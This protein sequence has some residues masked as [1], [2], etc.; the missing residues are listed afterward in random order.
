MQRTCERMCTQT[1]GSEHVNKS[2]QNRERKEHDIYLLYFMLAKQPL[3]GYAIVK[4]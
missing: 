2:V 3:R 4:F 1:H